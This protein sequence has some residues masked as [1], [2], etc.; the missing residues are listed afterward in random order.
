MVDIPRIE[1]FAQH[2]YRENWPFVDGYELIAGWYRGKYAGRRGRCQLPGMGSR[3][4]FMFLFCV[5][6][7]A[8]DFRFLFNRN[9]FDSQIENM[10]HNVKL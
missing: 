5:V 4:P 8:V 9:D 3:H 10:G 2:R 7:V 1:F 6:V